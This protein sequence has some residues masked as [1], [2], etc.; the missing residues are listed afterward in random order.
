MNI[1]WLFD[2]FAEPRHPHL[3][4]G[5]FRFDANYVVRTQS[6]VRVC[7]CVWTLCLCCFAISL[8]ISYADSIPSTCISTNYHFAGWW[9]VWL[10]INHRIC[11]WY[12]ILKWNVPDLRFV[13]STFS[14]LHSLPHSHFVSS[15]KIVLDSLDKRRSY[16]QSFQNESDKICFCAASAF[17][18]GIF[19]MFGTVLWLMER[20]RRRLAYVPNP[21]IGKCYQL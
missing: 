19:L 15:P 14:L 9:Y 10:W 18:F 3:F 17:L 21:P 12:V 4:F 11:V 6:Y 7:V 8:F 5:S 1:V 20:K 2:V 13:V 16:M